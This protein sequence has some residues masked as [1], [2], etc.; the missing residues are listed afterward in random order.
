MTTAFRLQIKFFVDNPEAVNL[1]RYTGLFQRWIQQKK[2]N[3]LL[4]DVVDYAH[5]FQGPGIVMI[6]HESD[7]A[8][9]MGNGQ[10]GLLYTRKRQT[11]ASLREQLRMSFYRALTACQQ[12]EAETKL[13]FR[14][15]D[16]EVRFLDRLNLPNSP[17]SL[18]IVRNDLNAVLT[19]VYCKPVNFVPLSVD[20]RQILTVGVQDAELIKVDALLNQFQPSVIS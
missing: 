16:P 12:L 19:E 9:D 6:G 13:R 10:P 2:L 18:D 11:D 20:P 5:V 15:N 4:I 1:P 17:E 14:A 7:Y 8:V 3:E